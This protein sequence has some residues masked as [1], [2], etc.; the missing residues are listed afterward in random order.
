MSYNVYRVSSA[1]MP[2]DHHAIFIET[3]NPAIGCGH[4]YQVTGNIQ[5]G[6]L[7][8]D[9]PTAFPPEHDPSFLGKVL[10]GTVEAA[11]HPDTFRRVCYSVS[12]PTKQFE[13]PHR[14]FPQEPIRR[15]QEWTS[16]TIDALTDAGILK[17]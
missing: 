17:R 16:E 6:M 3:N 7:Y 13:G 14:L 4:I 1:G 5:G 10:I 15:C 9:K 12:P 8:E 11:M 2:R